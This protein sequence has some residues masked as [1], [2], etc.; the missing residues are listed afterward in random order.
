VLGELD[1][2]AS[3]GRGDD[4]SGRRGRAIV[5]GQGGPGGGLDGG[6]GRGAVLAIGQVRRCAL[7]R[8]QRGDVHLQ[9][10]RGAAREAG[11]GHSPAR[12][13]DGGGHDVRGGPGR[14]GHGHQRAA[15]HGAAGLGLGR[16]VGGGE[17]R[18]RGRQQLEGLG[19]QRGGDGRV[20]RR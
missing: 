20:H 18:E 19:R 8:A 12:R 16:R 9:A 17:R 15:V 4:L 6:H 10:L 2:D 3:G 1:E 5:R 7:Q 13:A 11:L 14:A